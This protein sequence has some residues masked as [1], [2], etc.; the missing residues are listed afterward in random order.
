[1]KVE[2]LTSLTLRQNQRARAVLSSDASDSLGATYAFMGSEEVRGG[3]LETVRWDLR[4][5]AWRST[6]DTELALAVLKDYRGGKM[7]LTRVRDAMF[8][9]RGTHPRDIGN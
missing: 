9:W 7:D 3:T 8:R 5:E 2:D 6:D 1:M 4:L